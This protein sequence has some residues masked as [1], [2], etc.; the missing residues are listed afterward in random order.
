MP[1]KKELLHADS[2]MEITLPGKLEDNPDTPVTSD[3]PQTDLMSDRSPPNSE[4]REN[5]SGENGHEAPENSA[6]SLEP[7]TES[8]EKDSPT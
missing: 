6:V 4:N 3:D 5:E 8:G 1:K 7:P 2:D